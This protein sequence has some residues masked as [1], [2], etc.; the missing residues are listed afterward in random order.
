M[1]R[2]DDCQKEQQSQTEERARDRHDVSAD[3][4]E[5]KRSAA[6]KTEKDMHT[7]LD[8]AWLVRCPAERGL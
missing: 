1:T 8:M 6:E 5:K 7:K 4:G 2:E 3:L